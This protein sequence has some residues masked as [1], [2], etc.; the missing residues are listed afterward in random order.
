MNAND[1][2]DTKVSTSCL[3]RKNLAHELNHVSTAD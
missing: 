3:G 2:Y 1:D